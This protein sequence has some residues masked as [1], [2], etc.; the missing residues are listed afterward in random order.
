MKALKF[1]TTIMSFVI[2]GLGVVGIVTP[3]A[4]Y[5]RRGFAA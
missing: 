3:A 1:V 2:S 4:C 5:S